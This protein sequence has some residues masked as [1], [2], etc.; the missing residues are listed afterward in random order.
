MAA[1][2]VQTIALAGATKAALVAATSGGDTFVN[3]GKTV[4]EI[5]NADVSAMT[6]TITGQ[7]N[8]HFDTSATKTV[9]VGATTV[10]IVGPFPIGNYNVEANESV[11]LT[12][13][14]VTSL[15]VAAYSVND[16]WN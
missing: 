11:E 15:T 13:S 2:T 16:E 8:L 10:V 7:R 5:N 12:Y 3:E 4:I 6:L 14:S 1:L 9:S